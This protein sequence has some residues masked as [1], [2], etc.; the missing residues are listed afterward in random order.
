MTMV[1]EVDVVTA[2]RS[3]DALV[4]VR[5]DAEWIAGHATGAVHV[6][7]AHCRPDD[8]PDSSRV[9]VICRTGR[10]SGLAVRALRDA[11]LDAVNVAGGMKAWAAA[12]LPVVRD[13]GTPGEV[14]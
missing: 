11:G 13:D 12:G 1:P 10:R 7:L 6:P 3:T 9:L 4:D 5:E 2:A 14:L 8:L